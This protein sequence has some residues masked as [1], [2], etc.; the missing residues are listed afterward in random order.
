MRK[1]ILICL[2]VFSILILSGTMIVYSMQKEVE[3]TF[4]D[5]E[6]PLVVNVLNGTLT[7]ALEGAGYDVAKLKKQYIPSSPWDQEIDTDMKIQLVCN[8]KVTLEVGGKKEGSFQTTETTVGD[9]LKE[10]KIQLGKWDQVNA[11]LDQRIHNNMHIVVDR[12]EKVIKKR[13]ETVPFETEK[14]NDPKIAKGEE[15]I[16]KKGRNGERIYQIVT[17]YK[18]GKLLKGKDGKP[19]TEE[20]LIQEIPPV[21]QIVKVGTGEKVDLASSDPSAPADLKNAKVIKGQ[22]TGYT[23]TGNR[24]ATG[25]IPKRGT[26]AVDPRVIP[27]GSKLYIPGYGY[28]VAED[29]GGAV[30]GNIIDLFFE[31]REEAIKWG[32]RNVTIYVLN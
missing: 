7:D 1:I 29:T 20:T 5:Q 19:L 3:I 18:N 26:V 24:T 16:E 28:G 11:K 8:C 9:F 31:T 21:K 12:I 10:Q 4:S 25:T 17:I 6:K 23:H 14:E 15:K 2:G 32:R 30:K 13:V 22:A 27:L